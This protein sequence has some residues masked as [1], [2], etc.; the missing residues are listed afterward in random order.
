M[1]RHLLWLC[2]T[3]FLLLPRP[4]L[5]QVASVL[6]GEHDGFTRLVITL[7]IP[8]DWRLGRS[9]D[10]YVLDVAGR[11][12]G[13]DLGRVFDR[14]TRN[15]LSAIW[16]DPGDGR[17]NLGL[18][19]ACHAIP[20][21]YR[22]GVLVIDL[23]D[24]PPPAG[25]AF[26]LG[27]DGTAMAPLVAASPMRPRARSGL[28]PQSPDAQA[29]N[30]LDLR[31]QG[32]EGRSGMAALPLPGPAMP[33]RSLLA[34]EA[35]LL[36][37]FSRAAAEGLIDPVTR[38]PAA[39]PAAGR[40]DAPH[41][42]LRLGDTLDARTAL[43][44]AP[45]LAADGAACP[46]PGSLAIADWGD[47]RPVSLQFAE[48]LADLTGE[49]DHPDPEQVTRATRFLLHIGFGAEARA[50]VAAFP[51]DH[52]DLAL[53]RSMGRIVDGN[54]DPNGAFRG[55]AACDGPAALWAALA[56]PALPPAM[57]DRP[58]LLRAFSA[59][60]PALR[61]HLGPP[62]AER[63]LNA[64]D[65]ATA[66]ALQES[67]LR[68]P[69]VPDPRSQVMAARLSGAMGLE[70][71]AAD[72]LDTALAESGPAQHHA[73]TALVDLHLAEGRALDPGVAESLSAFLPQME[74]TPD[75][76][77]LLRAHVLALALSARFDEA[78]AALPA[79]PEATADL[80][81]LLAAGPDSAVLL[82]AIG[83]ESVQIPQETRS[84]IANRLVQLGF[85]DQAR[86]W[87]PLFILPSDPPDDPAMQ[88]DAGQAAAPAG[89]EPQAPETPDPLRSL[90]SLLPSRPAPQ[91]PGLA[92]G[93]DAAARSA[94]TRAVIESLLSTLPAP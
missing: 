26:E 71:Q 4:V 61:R 81:R 76:P 5:A 83:A 94:E 93:R 62:L 57:I 28:P 32:Q 92:Q 77:A 43:S 7:P 82:H 44:A 65:T 10:G 11:Q 69:G 89:T 14:I 35:D 75:H 53:W 86:L 60:P 38:L 78:F 18:A 73:L 15:R 41:G 50:L 33:D 70:S 58:A 55:M 56:D 47:T 42:N 6:S 79:A 23:R 2:L 63:F 3:L 34:L 9:D 17:L 24:G 72:H 48:S 12:P 66:T 40:P 64:E 49:F 21:E 59:L 85:P 31:M 90:A 22:P 19:C 91:A 52:P 1:P 46:D 8:G 67:I 39:V 25:S 27:L 30:W 84:A 80:W 88:S 54:A 51:T 29:F 16:A 74:G 37:D 20:F 68:L 45:A 13:F 87:S 36:M